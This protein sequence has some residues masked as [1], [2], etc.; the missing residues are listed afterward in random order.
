MK[1]LFMIMM[2]GVLTSTVQ[3]APG[4]TTTVQAQNDIW[5]DHFGNFDSTVNFPD[6]STKYR[7]ILMTFK[8]G[9][10]ACPGNP[11]YCGDW[12][13]TV[14]VFVTPKNGDT[15][16]LGRLITPYAGDGWPR[17]STSW[18]QR[19]VYDVTDFYPLLKDSCSIRIRYSGYSWGF[20]GNVKF[21][22]IEGVPPRNVL[23][24]DKLWTGSFGYGRATPIDDNVTT[25]TR[26]APASAVST[27]MKFTITGHGGDINNCSE[28]CS[29]YYQVKLNNNQIAQT[30]IWRDDC[31]FNHMYPQ[32]GTWIYNR[33]SWCPG[34]KVFDKIYK[35]S[36]VTGGN[37]YDI[38]V[39]FEAYTGAPNP[40]SG[41]Q[42]SYIIGANSF[43]YGGFN[44]SVDASLD[45]IIAPSDHE[46][47]FRENPMT[48]R[49]K[50]TI[51]NT[52][53]TTITSV[54]FKYGVSGSGKTEE[55][56]WQGSLA[57]LEIADVEL[58]VF[59]D[60]RTM[61][62]G[63]YDFDVE[64]LEVNGQQDEDATNNRMSSTFQT[65]KRFPMTI[66]VEFRTNNDV[67]NGVSETNWKIVEVFNGNTYYERVNNAP[68]TTY[69]DTVELGVGMYKLVVEDAGCNGLT[70]WANPNGGNGYIQVKRTTSPIAFPLKGDFD[71]DFG[72]GFS[73]YFNVDWPAAVSEIEIETPEL[74]IHPNPATS[75]VNVTLKGVKKPRGTIQL[76]DI[77][78]RVVKELSVNNNYI[79]INT[80]QLS[81][82]TYTV[83][84]IDNTN[85]VKLQQ[86][87]VLAK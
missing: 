4:D 63:T 74:K 76:L 3:A 49:P 18:T 34:D 28:F 60:F 25:I 37:S 87:V 6:G 15:Y 29:K 73:E 79:A 43:Y 36:N 58:G 71:G 57:P 35:L 19:Y 7:K 13:Y 81:S 30:D 69:K 41:S 78:G 75:Q 31:G 50:V 84:Y 85:S 67:V 56:T 70:W 62:S 51:Q 59:F 55:F 9:R 42:A 68:A 12:D 53:S 44:K 46:T 38:D 33:A 77:I 40:N 45:D 66:I 52:G 8:L 47:H 10:Y 2:L 20:T 11:Q 22:M 26:T 72:C 80:T 86:Q 14:S 83:V 65:A 16:E 21:D 64:I 48:G 39:D 54:K 61:S 5:M 24:V 1:K 17:T 27:E 32:N 23:S 82:G